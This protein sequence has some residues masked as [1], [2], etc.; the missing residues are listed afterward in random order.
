MHMKL[1]KWI[2]SVWA[3]LVD[4][5]SRTREVWGLLGL[6]IVLISLLSIPTHPLVL[7]CLLPHEFV[8]PVFACLGIR[9]L[10][11]AQSWQWSEQKQCFH[12]G[13][14]KASAEGEWKNQGN[15]S[16]R[17]HAWVSL[18]PMATQG[19][20]MRKREEGCAELGAVPVSS[21]SDEVLR[22]LFLV[23][24]RSCFLFDCFWKAVSQKLYR[25]W[26]V[27]DPSAL[28]TSL[29]QAVL[30]HF[31]LSQGHQESILSFDINLSH[32]TSDKYSLSLYKD[33]AEE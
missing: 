20:A 22:E 30:F 16:Q 6:F 28:C 29:G 26:Q 27:T 32:R 25:G 18:K 24:E 7:V 12:C 5:L 31:Q 10:A 1:L 21:L 4:A 8:S 11:E 15:S 33:L 3:T 9:G 13:K 17:T 2:D 14:C 23:Q 19:C